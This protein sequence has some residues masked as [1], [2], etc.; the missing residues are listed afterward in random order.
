LLFP[1]KENRGVLAS[2]SYAWLGA[3]VFGK[4]LILYGIWREW[5]LVHVEFYFLFNLFQVFSHI[6]LT[7][8]AS[9]PR[10]TVV[11]GREGTCLVDCNGMIQ[12]MMCDVP[13]L[14]VIWA[15]HWAVI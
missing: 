1:R 11:G 8:I 6:C 10:R 4:R 5:I 9:F 15:C 3:G 14:A 12:Q 13:D 7:L 2:T